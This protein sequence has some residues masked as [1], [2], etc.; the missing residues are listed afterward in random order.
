MT[1][2]APMS[3]DI[4]AELEA[5]LWDRIKAFVSPH[6]EQLV[7][8]EIRKSLSTPAVASDARKAEMVSRVAKIIREQA[9][10]STDVPMVL[11]D[12]QLAGRIIE[13]VPVASDVRD[14]ALEEAAKVADVSQHGASAAKNIRALIRNDIQ[15]SCGESVHYKGRIQ[16]ECA[17]GDFEQRIKELFALAVLS[18]TANTIGDLQKFTADIVSLHQNS[19]LPV[20]QEGWALNPGEPT[21]EMC[22]AGA[23]ALRGELPLV[24]E[25]R[26]S[27]HGW[28]AYHAYKAMLA[29]APTQGGR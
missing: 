5:A 23:E 26:L 24:G 11:N 6:R 15:S 25:L 21:K 29:A 20:A 12:I 22:E 14:A 10:C 1:T 2:Q 16:D 13:A 3:E 19:L 8:E 9:K 18:P 28:G 27:L 4:I 17:P 7:R